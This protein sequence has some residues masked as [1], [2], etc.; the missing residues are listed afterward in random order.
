MQKKP[1][2]AVFIAILVI[3]I[4]TGVWVWKRKFQTSAIPS[5]LQET[6]VKASPNISQNFVTW[7]DQLN[8]SFDYP[9]DAKIDKHDEDQDN[10]A[11]VELT[12]KDHPG[13]LIVW[14]KDPP[15]S[16]TGKI[17]TSAMEWIDAQDDL[18]DALVIDTT[19][20]EQKAKKVKVTSLKSKF[21]VVAYYDGLIY[22]IET[23]LKDSDY[24]SAVSEKVV[25][26]FAFTPKAASADEGGGETQAVD[27]EEV[28]E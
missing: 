10:Y 19:W 17:V 8:F 24:W 18:K 12:Q 14:A 22:Y 25:S 2:I 11:H 5:S 26:S 28:V 6:S 13:S 9:Q 21:Y 15:K 16:K 27:E 3:L 23:D 1:I 4:G 7:K 20:G